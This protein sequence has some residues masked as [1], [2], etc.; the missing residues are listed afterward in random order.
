MNDVKCENPRQ[1]ITGGKSV[2]C[3]TT[4]N[5]PWA[6]Q[7]Y[8]TENLHPPWDPAPSRTTHEGRTHSTGL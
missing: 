6:R 4:Q 8:R 3:V 1:R 5:C 7:P 2:H